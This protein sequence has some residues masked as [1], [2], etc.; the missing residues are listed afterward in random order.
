M[1]FSPEADVVAAVVVGAV[2]VDA[3]R[4]VRNRNELLLAAL[5]MLF[6]LHQLVEA[7]V[8]WSLDH[9]VSHDVGRAALWTYLVIAFVLPFLVPIAVRAVEPMPRR[10]EV[11]TW[12]AGLGAAVTTLLLVE[13]ARGPIAAH[14][15]GLHVSY[16][17]GRGAGAEV[18]VLYVAATCGALLASSFRLIALFGV[19]NLVAVATLAVLASNGLPSLWCFWAAT[20]SIVIAVH[21]RRSATVARAPTLVP[22]PA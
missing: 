10:R 19:L 14:A 2:G 4:H 5:P 8:W 17:I 12:C 22:T 3:L 11:M 9:S 16:D 7:F 18:V 15:S 13:I 1:C 20:T 6:A 21:L